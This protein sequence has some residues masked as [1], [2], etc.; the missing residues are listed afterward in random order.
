MLGVGIIN[1]KTKTYQEAKVISIVNRENLARIEAKTRLE[2]LDRV[3]HDKRDWVDVPYEQKEL[4]KQ[5][6]CRWDSTNKRWFASSYMPS[7]DVEKWLYECRIKQG[8]RH[9]M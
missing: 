7:R 8:E 6:G 9:G 3:S 4:A 1:V 5:V 2:Q